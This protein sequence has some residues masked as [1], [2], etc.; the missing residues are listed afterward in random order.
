MTAKGGGQ[1]KSTAEA[2]L[3]ESL[4][5][6]ASFFDIAA[7]LVARGKPSYD[8]DETLRLAAEAVVSRVGEGAARLPQEFRSRHP[9]VPW[10]KIRGMRNIV[11]HEYHQIDVEIVWRVL[12][13][14]L[15]KLRRQLNL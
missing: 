6:L 10:R 11:A 8:D 4:S 1:G 3:A 15:P 12:E 7:R 14:E 9:D 5:D 2:R 13:V